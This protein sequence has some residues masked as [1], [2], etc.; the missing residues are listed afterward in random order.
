M[1]SGKNIG[2]EEKEL[3]YGTNNLSGDVSIDPNG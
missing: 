3:F 1:Y 2:W